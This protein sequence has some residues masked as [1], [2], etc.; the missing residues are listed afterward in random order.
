MHTD[1]TAFFLVDWESKN[2]EVYGLKPG[3][4]SSSQVADIDPAHLELLHG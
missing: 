3:E 2:M 1:N 4:N